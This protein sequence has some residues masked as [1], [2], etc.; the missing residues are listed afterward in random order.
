MNEL[1]VTGKQSFMGID[2]PIIE[3]GFGEDKR[4]VTA[5]TVAEIHNIEIKEVTKSINRLLEKKRL[6]EN[7]DY[8][9]VVSQVNSLPM[10][11]DQIFSVK[12]A[13]LSRTKNIYIL[14][15]RGYTK[16]IKAMD[17][18]KSWEV[19]DQF[20]DEYFEMRKTIK[21]VISAEDLALLRICKSNSPEE[22]ALAVKEYRCVVTQPLV[23]ALEEQKPLVD[24]ANKVSVA[25]NNID[26]GKMAKLFHEKNNIDIGRNRLFEILRNKKI[27]MS[28]NTPY[29][30]Y[31]ERNWFKVIETTKDTQYG[32]K[33]FT[34]VLVTGSGQLKIT[35][36][37]LGEFSKE[38]VI[39]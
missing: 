29:Q 25:N 3:G 16:L 19:M 14:S 20:I 15:E 33:V 28:D 1:K 10:D 31:I 32:T 18:D 4:I 2:I 36:I 34:K 27:L 12:P 38:L 8:I 21:E 23:K 13:Y 39:A 6:K 26:M 35:D 11:L 17:D 7:V 5:K 22:T 24:F 37:I 9:D 30:T